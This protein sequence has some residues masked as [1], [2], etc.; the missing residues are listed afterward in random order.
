MLK[1]L[2]GG[3]EVVA[4]SRG[5]H[6]GV[7]GAFQEALDGDG[8]SV[9]VGA[10]LRRDVGRARA[11]GFPENR[12]EVAAVE[13]PF[14]E[15]VA[16][17]AAFVVEQRDDAQGSVVAADEDIFGPGVAVEDA[18]LGD[19]IE[20]G[21][22]AFGDGGPGAGF[23]MRH[24]ESLAVGEESADVVQD[25]VAPA[26]VGGGGSGPAEVGCGGGVD[27]AE[28]RGE[29]APE[30]V[31]LGGRE[32][33]HDG[34]PVFAFDEFAENRVAG[35]DR[36]AEIRS[37]SAGEK[38]GDGGEP[39]REAVFAAEQVVFDVEDERVRGRRGDAQD[40]AASVGGDE[41]EGVVEGAAAEFDGFGDHGAGAEQVR[42]EGG[43]FRGGG[44]LLEIGRGAR[45]GFEKHGE[46]MK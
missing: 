9:E 13:D 21:S 33:G 18:R 35:A 17:A 41:A 12:G 30:G 22:A 34:V 25:K 46:A 23:R 4:G 11:V 44:R 5:V 43:D 1:L 20:G 29:L 14:A 37:E 7:A 24:G 27:A 15:R 6:V 31:V 42:G 19:E 39:G 38:F 32:R 3:G 45:E 10:D 16:E 28:E 36:V 26:G 2:G 8:A 40:R